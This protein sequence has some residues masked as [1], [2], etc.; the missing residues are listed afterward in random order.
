M[1]VVHTNPPDLQK[2]WWA[3]FTATHYGS[4]GVRLASIGI[5]KEQQFEELLKLSLEDIKQRDLKTI[6]F[7]GSDIGEIEQ[8]CREKRQIFVGLLAYDVVMIG[9][10]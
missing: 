6:P 9:Y 2:L 1:V 4:G 5:R 10:D 8:E 7:I 3:L